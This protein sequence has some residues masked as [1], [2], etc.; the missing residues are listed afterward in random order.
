MKRKKFYH[1]VEDDDEQF[2]FKRSHKNNS[3]ISNKKHR[4][5]YHK[6]LHHKRRYQYICRGKEFNQNEQDII[7]EMKSDGWLFNRHLLP[8]EN[9]KLFEVILEFKKKI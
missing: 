9:D 2:S 7:N 8:L 5:N 4:P 3:S 1:E 6:H